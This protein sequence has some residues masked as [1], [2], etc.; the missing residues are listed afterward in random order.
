MKQPTNSK[1]TFSSSDKIK[2]IL[3]S[4]CLAILLLVL[5]ILLGI[6]LRQ[7]GFKF[8]LPAIQAQTTPTLSPA[9]V[10]PTILVP[11]VTCEGQTFVLGTTKFQVQ[12]LTF[13]LDGSLPTPPTTSG[14]AYW[15]D[16]TEGNHIVLLA[17]TPENISLETTLTSDSSA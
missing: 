9:Q 14:V 3:V 16:I 6:L 10:A 17:P 12:N 5:G 1:Q 15:F 11:T 4:I 13:A 7:S 2:I 8:S